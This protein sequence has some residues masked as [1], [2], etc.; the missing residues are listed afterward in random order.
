MIL[1]ASVHIHAGNSSVESSRYASVLA[2][3][4]VSIEGFY[5]EEVH[6]TWRHGAM[7]RYLLITMVILKWCLHL[8]LQKKLMN[9]SSLQSHL[10]MVLF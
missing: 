6:F 9:I 1:N 7:E 5:T 3:Y 10:E 8:I 4:N 2:N